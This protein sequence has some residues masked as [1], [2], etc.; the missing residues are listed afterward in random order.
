MP[1]KEYKSVL[2]SQINNIISDLKTKWKL[3][4]LIIKNLLT[5]LAQIQL[6]FS[7]FRKLISSSIESVDAKLYEAI[8]CLRM[9]LTAEKSAYYRIKQQ[10]NNAVNFSIIEF[11][12]AVLEII[13]TSINFLQPKPEDLTGIN[14]LEQNIHQLFLPLKPKDYS[15]QSNTPLALQRKEITQ[16]LVQKIKNF[17]SANEID[18]KAINEEIK[19]IIR[20]KTVGATLDLSG[21]NLTDL[22]LSELD[23]R[24]VDFFDSQ[25]NNTNFSGS[26]LR[27]ATFAGKDRNNR[28]K[29]S[30]NFAGAD[31]REVDFSRCDLRESTFDKDTK[32]EDMRLEKAW[33]STKVLVILLPHAR[34]WTSSRNGQPALSLN[35]IS[36]EDENL[37]RLDL[38]GLYLRSVYFAGANVNGTKFGDSDI[39]GAYLAKVKNFK[40][41]Q[42]A[43]CIGTPQNQPPISQKQSS[44]KR[45]AE[46]TH[47]ISDFFDKR[48]RIMPASTASPDSAEKHGDASE[49]SNSRISHQ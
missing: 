20:N 44:L 46:K 25:C 18:K 4:D 47:K 33:L 13:N 41:S 7:E 2:D 1:K 28:N 29:V 15:L 12:I 11:K 26:D 27:G 36:L 32:V 23:L 5:D 35:T 30:C 17:R 37:E 6:P 14:G 3:S 22:D 48:P 31:C 38:A 49:N 16:E 45:A 9:Y 24:A 34:W 43:E 40:L 8:C 39:S 10:S 21:L 19:K 42:L